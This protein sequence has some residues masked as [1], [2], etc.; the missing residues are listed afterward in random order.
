MGT[1]P[2]QN[3]QR[4]QQIENSPPNQTRQKDDSPS[5][6]RR[7]NTV[8][9]ESPRHA[10]PHRRLTIKRNRPADMGRQRTTLSEDTLQ[11]TQPEGGLQILDLKAR[12]EAINVMWL[13][14]YLD[15]S[16]SRPLWALATDT[17]INNTAP[18]SIP[19]KAIVNPFLQAW[20]PP[21]HSDQQ[22]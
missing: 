6:H 17:L 12:N 15:L 10:E 5:R 16:D 3:T 8:P 21:L 19:K 7:Q 2:R 22:G 4:T 13:K 9:H 18:K 14:S 11:D 1:N 20:K